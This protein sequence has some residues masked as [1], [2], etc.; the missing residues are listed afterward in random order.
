MLPRSFEPI[1]FDTGIEALEMY[2]LINGGQTFEII[3]LMLFFIECGSHFANDFGGNMKEDFYTPLI[4]TFK[5]MLT[6]ISA[7]DQELLAHYA[8][9]IKEIIAVAQKSNPAYGDQLLDYWENTF[10]NEID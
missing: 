8:P 10:I 6:K 3:E 5:K 4:S 1:A 2:E 9:R 7:G